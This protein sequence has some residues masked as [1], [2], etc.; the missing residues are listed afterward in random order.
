MIVYLD[1]NIIIY[2]KENF[3]KFSIL[4]N[5]N[6]TVFPYSNAHIQEI[7]NIKPFKNFSKSELVNEHLNF[8]SDISRDNLLEYDYGNKQFNYFKKVVFESY[9][10]IDNNILNGMLKSIFSNMALQQR[11]EIQKEFDTDPKK[12]NNINPN[13]VVTQLNSFVKKTT[14]HGFSEIT[15]LVDNLKLEIP[16]CPVSMNFAVI[17][18]LLDLV[19]YWRDNY[20]DKSNEARF[21]DSHHAFHASHTDIFVSDDK[22]TRNKA[23]VLYNIY[24]IETKVLSLDEFLE[25][26]IN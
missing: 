24:K 11:D 18:E 21:W 13:E 12:I 17:F 4:S 22:R 7:R 20:N 26:E 3:D 23:K 8:L 1:W 2:L 25:N 5:L 14:N 19:G 10:L 16:F 15:Q 9:Q 6:E